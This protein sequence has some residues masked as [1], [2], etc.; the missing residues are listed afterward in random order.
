MTA[1]NKLENISSA[2]AIRDIKVIDSLIKKVAV[3]VATAF[4]LIGYFFLYLAHFLGSIDPWARRRVFETKDNILIS[5]H[6]FG[7][8]SDLGDYV[9]YWKHPMILQ[10]KA[11]NEA[12]GR[13]FDPDV[14]I[15][16]TPFGG[17]KCFGAVS[18]FCRTWLETK[19]IEQVAPL[20][21]GGVPFE[22]S[23]VQEVYQ[24]SA[25]SIVYNPELVDL[26]VNFVND[27]S[28]QKT[29][30]VYN[31]AEVAWR[32][33]P[34]RNRLTILSTTRRYIDDGESGNL[35]LYILKRIPIEGKI[36]ASV[37]NAA[38]KIGCQSLEDA[39]LTMVGLPP[40]GL[41][42]QSAPIYNSTAEKLLE[43]C[44]TLQPG[45]YKLDFPCYSSGGS[46]QGFHTAG[47]AISATGESYLYDPN[48]AIGRIPTKN[49]LVPTLARLFTEYT[50]M[51]YSTGV[52]VRPA[53][54]TKFANFFRER[55]NPPEYD[56]IYGFNLYKVD[57][58]T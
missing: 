26:I 35:A 13:G 21:K 10:D 34:F 32:N 45:A 53:T 29:E 18:T 23:F 50:G 37:K 51:D 15:T 20:F 33:S 2:W 17:G 57:L 49:E 19:D 16:P 47:L 3:A 4:L 55:A 14:T 6:N 54:V 40:A 5:T 56:D 36:Y 22:S 9:S 25:T 42:M 52:G 48:F 39:E 38:E 28:A 7:K 1:S 12:R 27:Y 30:D 43:A 41:K 46:H 58:A 31:K 11:L 24:A 8:F 44:T